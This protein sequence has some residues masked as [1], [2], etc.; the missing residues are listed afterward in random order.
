MIK[1]SE[2]QKTEQ[3][4]D[5]QGA[6]MR[7]IVNSVRY[8]SGPSKDIDGQFNLFSATEAIF[9]DESMERRTAAFWDD[10]MMVPLMVQQNYVY[11]SK[12]I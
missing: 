4:I 11:S 9:N 3:M 6:D 2:K 7:H 10:Y 12:K 1:E 8:K 5:S